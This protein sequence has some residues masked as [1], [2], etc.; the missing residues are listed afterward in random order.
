MAGA[1]SGAVD[2]GFDLG[3]GVAEKD[4]VL[5]NRVGHDRVGLNGESCWLTG[6]SSFSLY[7]TQSTSATIDGKFTLAHR[8]A[9]LP[10]RR[11]MQIRYMDNRGGSTLRHPRPAGAL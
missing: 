9:F 6:P 4:N 2:Y 8:V 1:V 10:N 11:Q 5:R 3:I 7:G